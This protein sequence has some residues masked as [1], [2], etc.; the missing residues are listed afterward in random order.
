MGEIPKKIGELLIEK[1]LITP[2]QLNEALMEQKMSG[3][4]LGEIIVRR[5]WA[6]REA[7]EK[8]LNMQKGITAFNLSSYIIEPEVIR[9]IPEFFA[10]KYKIMPVFIVESTLT[11]AMVDPTNV[12]VIDEI[13]RLTKLNVEPVSCDEIEIRKAQDQYYGPTGSLQ[14]IVSSIDK[15]K[16]VEADKLGEEAPIIK[17]VNYLIIQ[18]VQ[19]KASDIHIEPEENVLN[20]RYRIDGML[21]RQPALPKDLASA[22]TSRFKIMAGLDIAE[23]RLP[24]D[25]RIMMKIGSKDIDFRVSTCP[26]VHGENIVLRI[27]DKSGLVLGLESLGFPPQT[28]ATFKELISSPYGILLVTGPTGSGKTTTLYS[29]LQLLNKEDV[30]IMTVEDPVEY[31]FPGMRQVQVN[32]VAGL[33]F[34][35]A[36]RSFLRQ[37]PDIIMVGEI[38]DLET[39]EIAVQAALTGHMVFST[40]HTND[41]PS[42]F[43]RLMNMGVEPFLISSSILGVLAQRLLRKVCD[44]CKESYEPKP[45][46]LKSLGLDSYINKPVTFMKGRGCK[47]C[48]QTGYKGR[49]GIYELL[50][51]TPTIQEA[52]LKKESADVIRELAIKDGLITLRQAA[53]QKLLGGLTTPEEVM[54]VTLDV[55]G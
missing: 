11:V 50:K 3:G 54:R 29:A 39:A 24:Q 16:L 48:N 37:D 41:S 38:R 33:T 27:L 26:T 53:L 36:L 32:P 30:N 31:Q 44:K 20:V 15:N 12:Y 45:E 25:G 55:E 10:R 47:V 7:V 23:K 1:G 4:K 19:N 43:T 46:L 51:V 9:L 18:A 22:I 17:I 6:S 35:T 28:L 40:L 49:T 42:A 8:C 21:H 13:Q 5:G 2:S 14:E 52:V 34:A